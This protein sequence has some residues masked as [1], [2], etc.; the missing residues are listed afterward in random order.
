MEDD[1][2]YCSVISVPIRYVHCLGDIRAHEVKHLI[3]ERT[4]LAG[5]SVA[6]HWCGSS[7]AILRVSDSL[8]AVNTR[9]HATKSLSACVTIRIAVLT[10][11]NALA[12]LT[13]QIL[14]IAQ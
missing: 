2:P 1:C 12:L 6:D 8:R 10:R 11:V 4:N 13:F 9:L 5:Y 7:S 14:Y 3:S